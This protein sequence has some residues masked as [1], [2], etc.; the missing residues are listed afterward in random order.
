MTKC[1]LAKPCHICNFTF[2]T[3]V[4]TQLTSDSS[5]EQR[6][7]MWRQSQLRLAANRSHHQR[8]L[9]RHFWEYLYRRGWEFWLRSPRCSLIQVNRWSLLK[10]VALNDFFSLF[11]VRRTDVSLKRCYGNCWPLVFR[12]ETF[13][14]SP[15]MCRW[16]ML[17]RSP[18]QTALMVRVY[19]LDTWPTGDLESP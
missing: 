12:I 9:D 15:S 10:S 18:I 13:R 2:S 6:R 19:G 5:T 17:W 1:S 7:E 4:A 14:R 16:I 3:S 11:L 8:H